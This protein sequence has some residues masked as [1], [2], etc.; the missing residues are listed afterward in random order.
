MGRPVSVHSVRPW[1]EAAVLA[2]TPPL[3]RRAARRLGTA[4][5]PDI[6]DSAGQEPSDQGP[7]GG[8]TG[9]G[10]PVAAQQALPKLVV[11]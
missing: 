11:F 4:C 10:S 1:A 6:S 2:A 9:P 8:G 7:A 3:G 5:A